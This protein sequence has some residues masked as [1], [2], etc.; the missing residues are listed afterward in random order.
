[1]NNTF[2]ALVDGKVSGAT[3]NGD[4][5]Q[6]APQPARLSHAVSANSATL[7]CLAAGAQ[8]YEWYEDGVKIPD[9]TGDSLTLNWVTA[10]AKLSNNVHTYSVVPV[11]SVFNETVRG[12]AASAE[13]EYTPRGTV[14]VIK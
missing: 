7:T 12:D 9:E 1:M 10:K 2:S 5:F 13:V 11:Y 6:I 3:I 8:S 4:T 14:M